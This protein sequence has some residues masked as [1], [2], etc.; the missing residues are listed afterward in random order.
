MPRA[1]TAGFWDDTG[2]EMWLG[3]LH[4]CPRKAC[5][6]GES[7]MQKKGRQWVRSLH[8]AQKIVNTHGTVKCS[9]PTFRTPRIGG[10]RRHASVCIMLP[11]AA[12]MLSLKQQQKDGNREK[13][14]IAALI[15]TIVVSDI[16]FTR[17]HGLEDGDDAGR[18]PVSTPSPWLRGCSFT[19]LITCM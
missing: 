9:K 18:T 2:G 4:S 12:T 17:K 1:F 6:Q 15:Q 3:R 19:S 8:T 13:K 10:V 16:L 7:S 11:R 14:A 5:A